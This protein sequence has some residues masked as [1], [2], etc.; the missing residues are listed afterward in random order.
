[1]RI[2]TDSDFRFILG[3]LSPEGS[4]RRLGASYGRP[5]FGRNNDPLGLGQ[6]LL[7]YQYTIHPLTTCEIGSGRQIRW[8]KSYE[9][10]P[11]HP[12]LSQRRLT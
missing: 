11:F 12:S 9:S 5:Y 10:Q 6:G 7:L 3:C 8:Q 4:E 2:F 1:M